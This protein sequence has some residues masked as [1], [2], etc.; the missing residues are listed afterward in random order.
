M[1]TILLVTNS[2]EVKNSLQDKVVLL[3]DTDKLISVNYENYGE[4]FEEFNPY[5]VIL[6]EN[7]DREKTIDVLKHLNIK[8]SVSNTTVI[9][10]MKNKDDDFLL[11]AYDEGA[12]EYMLID[13]SPAE[14]LI[15]IV[16]CIRKVQLKTKL[17]R[18]E[19]AMEFCGVT[20][21]KSAF[22]TSKA[23]EDMI[24]VELSKNNYN[25]ACYV[26]ISVDDDAKKIYSYEKMRMVIKS[27][28]RTTD[29]VVAYTPS[30][31]GF[32]LKT[33]VSGAVTVFKRIKDSLP[34]E[35]NL[36]AGLVAIGGMKFNEIN[37]KAL[38]ALNEAGLNDDRYSI[39]SDKQKENTE[40]WLVEEAQ[41]SKVY[42]F[43][44]KAFDKKIENII[45]PIFYRVQRAYEDK[46]GD[47]KIEQFTDEKQ[48]VFRIIQ[49]KKESRLTMLY[50]GYSKLVIYISHSGLDSPENREVTISLKEI[51][52]AKISEIVECFVS[53][54][55]GIYRHNME[56]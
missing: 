38:S 55:I 50:P 2:D 46:V 20:E 42:K 5:I 14:V 10:L 34:E 11:R 6:D 13:Y 16:N 31:F 52:Q 44:K 37:K 19:T 40:N 27:Y 36:K 25:G 41:D 33:D 24:N 29:V 47:A 56:V 9:L 28:L 49:G 15:R 1:D 35:W 53:E 45:S 23:A 22:Y 43:Y 4:V 17:L 39:Y 3:R 54:Y 12:D 21:Q 30:K 18:C 8:K 26:I 32:L 51:T 48:S 7:I